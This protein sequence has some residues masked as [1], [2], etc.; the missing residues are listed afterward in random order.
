MPPLSTT[1]A[2]PAIALR[3]DDERI[4]EIDAL[5]TQESAKVGKLLTRSDMARL[6][7]AE[8][9]AARRKRTRTTF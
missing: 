2:R 6:L 5:A 9:I 3:L 7:M 1:R 8:A 4:D